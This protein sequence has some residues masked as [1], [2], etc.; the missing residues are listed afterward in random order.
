MALCA[1]HFFQAWDQPDWLQYENGLVPA[2]QADRSFLLQWQYIAYPV[3][4]FVA[5]RGPP[6]FSV[7]ETIVNTARTD[8]KRPRRHN[9]ADKQA[10]VTTEARYRPRQT[11][12]RFST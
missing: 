12:S 1:K 2:R 8:A 4:V 11:G 7:L 5:L 10:P 9:H 3:Q 6:V